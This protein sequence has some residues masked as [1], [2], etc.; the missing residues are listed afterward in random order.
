MQTAGKDYMWGATF[1]RTSQTERLA[2]LTYSSPFQ[3][4][5]GPHKRPNWQDLLL[6][7]LVHGWGRPALHSVCTLSCPLSR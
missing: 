2:L 1:C 4:H 7:I 5:P 3:G 6:A